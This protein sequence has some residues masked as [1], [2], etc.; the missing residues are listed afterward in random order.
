M[1]TLALVVRMLDWIGKIKNATQEATGNILFRQFGCN[2]AEYQH[3][4]VEKKVM[5]LYKQC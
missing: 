2:Q 3:D 1:Q 5:R 4:S